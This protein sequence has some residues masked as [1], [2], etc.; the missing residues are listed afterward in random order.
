LPLIFIVVAV[1]RAR[2]RR[3]EHSFL[4]TTRG[5]G[6]DC[7]RKQRGA[8]MTEKEG[9]TW[10]KNQ[11]R[12]AIQAATAGTPIT[13]DLVTAIAMQESYS[14]AWGLIYKTMPVDEILMR[15]VGDTF[16]APNRSAF[17]VDKA[18][19]LA[20]AIPN[21][22]QMF[23]IAR[24]AL[25]MLA[26][27]NHGYSAVSRNPNKFCHGYGIF[28]YDIQFFKEIDP[29]FFLQ[30]KWYSFD[31]CLQKCLGELT[32]G[33]KQL[34]PGNNNLTDEQLTYVAIGYNI[35]AGKVRL[36][37]GFKQGHEDDGIF[38]GENI[39]RYLRLAHAV[40]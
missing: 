29:D 37:G 40:P 35:G 30:K 1:E 33:A 17:P 9:M 27:F 34:Y 26:G 7:R 22:Q 28:Q 13:L 4:A 8:D 6:H 5:I 10:F 31:E 24:E 15:C 18:A 23:D 25:T 16:D 38:Y 21:G 12:N 2:W 39:D 36:D 14:D 11:F 20:P 3:N 19:L 32:S